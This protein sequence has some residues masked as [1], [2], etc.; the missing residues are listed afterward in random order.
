VGALRWQF[1]GEKEAHFFERREWFFGGI[2][3]ILV[4]ISGFLGKRWFARYGD[5]KQSA[6]V[7]S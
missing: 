2:G 6:G 1:A 5:G 7:E 3:G 4:S